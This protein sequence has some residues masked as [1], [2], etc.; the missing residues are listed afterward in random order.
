MNSFNTT[1]MYIL[2]YSDY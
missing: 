1:P 2:K